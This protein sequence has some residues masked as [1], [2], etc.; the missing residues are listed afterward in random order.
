MHAVPTLERT[1][2]L[3]YFE[4]NAYSIFCFSGTCL[5]NC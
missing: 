3:C 2:Y 4:N 1:S 5:W